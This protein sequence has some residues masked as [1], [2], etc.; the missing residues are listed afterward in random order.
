MNHKRTKIS[1]I[2]ALVMG[3][4]LMRLLPNTNGFV[5][6]T[7]ATVFAAAFIGRKG[8]AVLLPIFSVWISDLILNNTIY[9]SFYEGF[10][11]L[12]PGFAFQFSAYA[13]I[14]LMGFQIGQNA[15]SARIG[16]F[17][18]ASSL[19]FFFV[20]NF[21]VWVA[22]GF[23]APTF[24]GLMECYA[25]G[26]PF[27]ERSLVADVLFAQVLFHGFSMAQRRFPVLA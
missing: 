12:T 15:S 14:S 23:Y 18:I 22:G 4:G 21:G 10:T 26:L 5:P 19:I 13:L 7:A 17:S 25:M 11:W 6:V 3:A 1:V 16:G 9:S 8:W 2:V 20:T 24:S 27:F